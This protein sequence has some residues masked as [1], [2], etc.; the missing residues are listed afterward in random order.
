MKKTEKMLEL[1]AKLGEPIEDFLRREYVDN[2]K[3]QR[4]IANEHITVTQSTL[5]RWLINCGIERPPIRFTE[6]TKEEL[7]Q[8][9]THEH[10][11]TIKIAEELGVVK[12]K[13]R[14]WL[15]QY[16]VPVRTASEAQLPKDFTKPSKE[17]LYHL[18]ITQG[19]SLKKIAKELGTSCITICNWLKQY[20]I[21]VRTA[22]EARLPNDLTKPTKEELEQ[23]YVNEYKSTIK[24][25]EEFGVSNKTIRN[26]LN[27]Y[28]IPIRTASEAQLPKDFTRP[29]KEELEQQY[30]H[31]HKSTIKIAGELGVNHNTVR[32]WL[33]QY[34]IQIRSPITS[35]EKFIE[36]IKS[37]QT[38]ATLA[39]TA[40]S[41][42]GQSYDIEKIITDLYGDKFK[43]KKQLHQLLQENR[44]EI[45]ELVQQG[46]TNLG[47]YLGEFTLQDRGIIPILIDET[48]LTLPENTI[49]TSLEDRLVNLLRNEYSPKFNKDRY[50]TLEEIQAKIQSS[51]GKKQEIYQKLEAH[52]QEVLDLEIELENA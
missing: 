41:L 30:I 8:L 23:R 36:F 37:D 20:N 2:R 33:K 43:D 27:Q 5:G 17:E 14:N 24:I 4:Q 18:Y 39:A 42:N 29:T 34:N 49:T 21:P 38:A 26:W 46:I 12:S 32:N 9:Y 13:V 40:T 6:P 22:S 15:K 50:K 35:S 31:E 25:A 1:E 52:Y 7:D 11:S 48:I 51:E 28:N 47:P 16:N 3:S 10:K 19:N 44:K 45:L